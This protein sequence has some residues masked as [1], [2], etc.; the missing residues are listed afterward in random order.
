[1][2]V[3]SVVEVA[4]LIMG[5]SASGKQRDTNDTFLSMP[6]CPFRPIFQMDSEPRGCSGRLTIRMNQS[7]N[8]TQSHQRRTTMIRKTIIAIAAVATVA[9]AA[10]APTAAS[11]FPKHHHH[12]GHWGGFGFGVIDVAPVADCYLVQTRGG[13]LVKVC[14]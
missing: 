9:G 11:A 14:D 4:R 6:E 10:L 2:F 1:M 12:W 7:T 13:R 8:A 5:S 3:E